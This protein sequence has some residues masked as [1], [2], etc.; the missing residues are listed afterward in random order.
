MVAVSGGGG[1][2]SVGKPA[3]RYKNTEEELQ[4]MRKTLLMFAAVAAMLAAHASL[5][6]AAGDPA[7]DCSKGVIY[8]ASLEN[9]AV[10]TQDKYWGDPL[11]F[12]DV[13]TYIL[14]YKLMWMTRRPVIV[15][16]IA[17]KYVT[18]D[19]KPD[20]DAVNKA[21]GGEPQGCWLVY[22]EVTQAEIATKKLGIAGVGAKKKYK[23]S[24]RVHLTLA[25]IN[26]GKIKLDDDFNGYHE[27]ST[28]QA[29]DTANPDKRPSFTEDPVEAG[30]D[31]LGI[32]FSRIYNSFSDRIR[33]LKQLED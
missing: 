19:G 16:D 6:L 33:A 30:G 28:I 13:T 27:T 26:T 1:Q 4:P 12:D 23:I 31:A 11:L 18:K 32:P 15:L 10:L 2:W 25:D 29:E 7:Q 9:K 8:I 21:I 22:G 17:S 14:A 24:V 5:A 3:S 20:L